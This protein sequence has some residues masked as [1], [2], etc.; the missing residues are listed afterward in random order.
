MTLASL[1][2]LTLDIED[3]YDVLDS[4]HRERLAPTRIERPYGVN[5]LT[6]WV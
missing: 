4:L 3:G 5:A 1:S 6:E 2:A